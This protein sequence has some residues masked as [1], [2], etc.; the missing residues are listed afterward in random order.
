MSDLSPFCEILC[1]LL[2]TA[3]CVDDEHMLNWVDSI[4]YQGVDVRIVI[5]F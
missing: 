4:R 3:V 5:T 2:V 1:D